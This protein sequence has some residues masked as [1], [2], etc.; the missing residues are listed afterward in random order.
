[1]NDGTIKLSMELRITTDAAGSQR[2][3]LVG[4]DDNGNEYRFQ[5][6]GVDSYPKHLDII[7]TSANVECS[8]CGKKQVADEEKVSDT[9]CTYCGCKTLK[10][11]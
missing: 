3:V 2:A 4:T 11:V 6:E 10:V 1:M 9:L 5:Y 7:Q 8:N